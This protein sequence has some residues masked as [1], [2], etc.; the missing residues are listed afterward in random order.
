MLRLQLAFS[1]YHFYS[2]RSGQDGQAKRFMASGVQRNCE[3]RI[4]MPTEQIRQSALY[5]QFGQLT[6]ADV[7][8]EWLSLDKAT[9]E[10]Y[11]EV[12]KEGRQFGVWM[13]AYMT[14]DE[15]SGLL[16]G[17]QQVLVGCWMGCFAPA[18]FCSYV[19]NVCQQ[20]GKCSIMFF[21]LGCC[22]SCAQL[23]CLNVLHWHEYHQC[24][25]YN[26]AS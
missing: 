24:A 5:P 3:H 12:K 6:T 17:S 19:S 9:L 26:G 10:L 15:I 14:E 18:A 2:L 21:L 8:A 4:D 22:V 13:A 1:S 23:L 11:A 25:Y 7:H 20:M 16:S